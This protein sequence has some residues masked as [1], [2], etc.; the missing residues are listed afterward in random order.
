MRSWKGVGVPTYPLVSI[1]VPAYQAERYL[2]ATL[3]SARAQT[4]ENLEIVVLDNASTD[5][6]AEIL[7]E[8]TD[9]RI[10]VERNDTVLPLSQNWNRVVEMSKGD[11]VKVLCADDLIHPTAVA[12]QAAVLG[13][14]PGVSLV[15][16]RR[17][18]VDDQ[19]QVLAA[20]KGLAGLVGRHDGGSVA[21]TVVRN[22]GNP[23]GEPAGVLFRRADFDEVGGFD[24]ALPF[25]MDL[26]LWM[27]LLRHG[28][29]V[30]LKDSLAAFRASRDSLSAHNAKTL[31]LEQR[32]LTRRIAEDP[33]WGVSRTSQLLGHVGAVRARARRQALFAAAAWPK[34]RLLTRL[35]LVG[36]ASWLV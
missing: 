23:I 26:D 7:A 5:R 21:T 31:Y 35:A 18:F 9:P 8:V 19:G 29:L 36:D 2:E 24:P 32:A 6:T 11:F 30:G 27:R 16:A 1:V 34:R 13:Q 10:R 25:P 28:D 3:R 12:V 17:H 33:A 20:S 14:H 15:A 4:Y 22:G